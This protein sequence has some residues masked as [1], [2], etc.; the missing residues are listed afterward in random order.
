MDR[1]PDPSWPLQSL[2]GYL[3]LH[4][5]SSTGQWG[6]WDRGLKAT[7]PWGHL[8][9]APVGRGCGHPASLLQGLISREQG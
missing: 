7:E 3:R 6:P 2:T 1:N 5:T 8:L 9:S 4:P